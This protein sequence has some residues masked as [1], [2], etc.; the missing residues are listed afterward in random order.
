MKFWWRVKKAKEFAPL[1]V[2]KD[3]TPFLATLC[4]VLVD[5]WNGILCKMLFRYWMDD[6]ALKPWTESSIQ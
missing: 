1:S 3:T 2:K 4:L 5:I 6:A